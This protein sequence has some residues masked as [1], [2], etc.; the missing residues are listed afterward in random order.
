MVMLNKLLNFSIFV[1]AIV[2]VY[3]SVKLHNERTVIVAD[4]GKLLETVETIASSTERGVKGDF[5]TEDVQAAT[6]EAVA[7]VLK[8]KN[9]LADTVVSV[10]KGV[11]I[12]DG[13]LVANDLK[14]TDEEAMK[15]SA[16]AI[17]KA[18]Q[19]IATRDEKIV[20]RIQAWGEELGAPVNVD[21]L[22]DVEGCDK[23]LTEIQT[24]LFDMKSKGDIFVSTI[25]EGMGKITNYEWSYSPDELTLASEFKA[26]LEKY[27]ADM[28]TISTQ[29]A[30]VRTLEETIETKDGEIAEL[31]GSVKERNAEIVDFKASIATSKKQIEDLDKRLKEYTTLG[32]LDPSVIGEVV[33]VNKEYGF[34]VTNLGKEKTRVD[35]KMYVRRGGEYIA[36]VLISAVEK[37][38]S[39]A[40]IL[41]TMKEGDV[42]V[43][44]KVIFT[45]GK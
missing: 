35:E 5:N 40:E 24:A 12:A 39:V 7:S 37:D 17:I 16:A 25:Q 9:D 30:S 31:K 13:L 19:D 32:I 34:V 6:V 44:D 23:P 43:G 3:F 18:A 20:K 22:A 11:K 1:L 41:P 21:Q 45:T 14:G 8:Q 15:A 28:S 42:Q 38:S 27:K 10:G 36:S 26:A 33:S 29:L 4:R 2:S